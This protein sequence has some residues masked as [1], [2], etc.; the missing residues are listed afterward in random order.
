MQILLVDDHPSIGEGTKNMLEQDPDI[1]VTTV[2][3][4]LKALEL[5]KCESYD[6]I[7][8]DLNMPVISGLELSKRINQAAYECRVLIYTGYEISAH[9]NRY[10]S[11]SP[12][13]A[14]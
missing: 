1:K 4:A 9:F 14:A 12:Q 10:G 7:L 11:N 6:I 2:L 13:L 8:C 5:L 3:S